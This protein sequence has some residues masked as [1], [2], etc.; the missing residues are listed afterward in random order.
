MSTTIANDFLANA[1]GVALLLVAWILCV[2]C[3]DTHAVRQRIRA[4]MSK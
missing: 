1:I 2:E 3:R 4:Q